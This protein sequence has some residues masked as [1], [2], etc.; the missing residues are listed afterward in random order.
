MRIENRSIWRYMRQ[1]N[2]KPTEIWRF[3]REKDANI[4]PQRSNY[5]AAQMGID[6]LHR[7]DIL[8]VV[9]RCRFE[10]DMARAYASLT[11]SERATSM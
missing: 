9:K 4:T 2:V 1:Y 3:R 10:A 7:S 8:W 11:R 5:L 6:P